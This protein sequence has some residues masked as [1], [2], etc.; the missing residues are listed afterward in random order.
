MISE[1]RP[2]SKFT[3]L[4]L[5]GNNKDSLWTTLFS[6]YNLLTFSEQKIGELHYMTWEYCQWIRHKKLSI[7]TCKKWQ[8]MHGQTKRS[9]MLAGAWDRHHNSHQLV[10]VLKHYTKLIMGGDKCTQH[11][12]LWACAH[13]NKVALWNEPSNQRCW[14]SLVTTGGSDDKTIIAQKCTV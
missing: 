7:I 10:H 4:C 14:K 13:S 5:Y 2:Q 8:K 9:S 1:G 12:Q 11:V 6:A 3:N